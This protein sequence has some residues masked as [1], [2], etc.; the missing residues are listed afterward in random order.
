MKRILSLIIS[1]FMLSQTVFASVYDEWLYG[2]DAEVTQNTNVN[3]LYKESIGILNGLGLTEGLYFNLSEGSVITRGDFI[4]LVMHIDNFGITGEVIGEIPFS[5]VSAADNYAFAVTEA[6]KKRIIDGTGAAQFNP[7]EPLS[8]A[9]AQ[10]ILVNVLGYKHIAESKGG[11][12]VGYTSLS[13]GFDMDIKPQNVNAL[14]TEEAAA[15]IVSALEVSYNVQNNSESVSFNEDKTWLQTKYK[16]EKMK[17]IVEGTEKSSLYSMSAVGENSVLIDGIIYETDFDFTDFLGK[18]VYY[19]IENEQKVLYA[20]ETSKNETLVIGADDIEQISGRNIKYYEGNKLTDTDIPKN[21][22]VIYNNI[23]L[24]NYKMEDLD[25]KNGRL[26]LIS[27]NG[28]KEYTV[29]KVFEYTPVIVNGTDVDKELIYA[30][31]L[32]EESLTPAPK[33]ITIDCKE[34]ESFEVYNP[35]GEKMELKELSEDRVLN[36]LFAQ[37]KNVAK[38]YMDGGVTEGLTEEIISDEKDYVVINANKLEVSPV[39]MTDIENFKTGENVL[40]YTDM[41]DKI[42]FVKKVSLKETTYAYL[43]SVKAVDDN[44][45][46]LLFKLYDADGKIKKIKSAKRLFVNDIK[47]SDFS[48][49]PEEISTAT[50]VIYRLDEYGEMQKIYTPDAVNSPLKSICPENSDK[51]IYTGGSNYKFATSSGFDNTA[52]CLDANTVMLSIPSD[53][54]TA[55]DKYFGVLNPTDFVQFENHTVQAYTQNENSNMAEFV[56]SHKLVGTLAASKDVAIITDMST[57]INSNDDVV[58]I[59]TLTSY[60]F[61]DKQ[62]ITSS[63]E[64]VKDIPFTSNDKD[65]TKTNAEIG[66]LIIYSTNNQ[67]EIQEITV[68][69]K[70]IEPGKD[71]NYW[72]KATYNGAWYSNLSIYRGYLNN[73]KERIGEFE[74]YDNPEHKLTFKLHDSMVIICVDKEAKWDAERIEYMDI[75]SLASFENSGQ[76][77]DTLLYVKTSTPRMMII[78]K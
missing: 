20:Y 2:T 46:S 71:F 78:Y 77:Y 35:K 51:L 23:C 17:G 45:T 50:A 38:A 54:Q 49:V 26:E 36:I 21:A 22:T 18:S 8:Y 66:D 11:F 63:L 44:E 5:D 9:A 60:N 34:Y 42:I 6:A 28:E 14:N 12:P 7:D 73:V 1:L 72:T 59:L 43:I 76:R 15:M 52:F 48:R 37:N 27:N 13:A 61:K 32:E 4:A 39:A 57:G 70:A 53:A 24:P 55:E 16:T 33:S 30:T 65:I 25:I 10:K 19:Y 41:F 74:L 62:F 69:A 47:V 64:V 58:S 68:V 40:V 75:A 31:V 67:N 3:E 56:L 29:V